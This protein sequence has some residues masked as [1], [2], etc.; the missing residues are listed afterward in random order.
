MKCGYF[1]LKFCIDKFIL[2][3]WQPDHMLDDAGAAERKI[4]TKR[5]QEG[6]YIFRSLLDGGA[7][8]ALGSDWPV[9]LKTCFLTCI[10]FAC[11]AI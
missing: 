3:L 11:M 4:G 5:A 10:L 9:H 1:H 2:V 6:S 7:R 8:L